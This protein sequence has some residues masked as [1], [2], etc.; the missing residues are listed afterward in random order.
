M[1][2]TEGYVHISQEKRVGE[3]GKEAQHYVIK[4]V[5]KTGKEDISY[6]RSQGVEREIEYFAKAINGEKDALVSATGSPRGA[7]L[8]VAIIEASLTSKGQ[9]VDLQTLV[10]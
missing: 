5:D 7:L 4:I 9:L 1:T 2:G 10:K 6:H 8:D 3:D